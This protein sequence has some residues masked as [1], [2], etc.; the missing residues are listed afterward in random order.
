MILSVFPSLLSWQQLSPTL[1]RLTLASVLIFWS[2]QSLS[3]KSS[4][5]KQKTIGIIEGVSG[6]L[7]VLGIWSQVAALITIINLTIRLYQKIT[8]KALLTNGINYYII[9]LIL[10]ISILLT[11]AGL[12][13]FDRP[14]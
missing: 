5:I 4:D 1:I 12:F 2:Y 11:G 9:L 14:I 3:N 13:G 6:I 7:L 8:K 10:A